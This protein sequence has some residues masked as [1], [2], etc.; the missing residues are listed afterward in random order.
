MIKRKEGRCGRMSRHEGREVMAH[1]AVRFYA[2]G[3]N[4]TNST[5]CRTLTYT[6]S[7]VSESS[8]P[9]PPALL[10]W[11]RQSLML[12]AASE[13]VGISGVSH[14]LQPASTAPLVLDSL[15]CSSL[16]TSLSQ[17]PQPSTWPTGEAGA[18]ADIDSRSI[19]DF[20][21]PGGRVIG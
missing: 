19:S 18:F 13:F 17:S 3:S 6:N 16:L 1:D 20:S 11:V 12:L 9:G 8:P 7:S 4:R 2:G 5:F 10:V 15:A 21:E 14:P